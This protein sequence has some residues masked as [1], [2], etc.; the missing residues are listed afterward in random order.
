MTLYPPTHPPPTP[1]TH[2]Q[3]EFYLPKGSGPHGI[4]ISPDERLLAVS[5]YFIDTQEAGILRM[6]GSRHVY[7][8]DIGAA[9]PPWRLQHEP[10][11]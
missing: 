10:A 3:Q 9:T 4:S 11:G 8:F 2:P 5:T 6:P 7:L 1:P